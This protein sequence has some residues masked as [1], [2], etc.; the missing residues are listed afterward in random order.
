ME[1]NHFVGR[2]VKN[3]DMRDKSRVLARDHLVGTLITN[4]IRYTK[5]HICCNSK[6]RTQEI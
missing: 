3:S 1:M 2:F 5:G 4:S 6:S